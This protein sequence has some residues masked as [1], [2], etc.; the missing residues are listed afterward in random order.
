MQLPWPII[1][2]LF[3]KQSKKLLKSS[4]KLMGLINNDYDQYHQDRKITYSGYS[5]DSDVQSNV[6]IKWFL[7]IKI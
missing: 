4:G 2:L 6:N 7:W 5:D 1:K 3:I